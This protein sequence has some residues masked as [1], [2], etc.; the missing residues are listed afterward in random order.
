MTPMPKRIR[1]WR[2]GLSAVLALGLAHE[3]SAAGPPDLD[4][5]VRPSVMS[6]RSATALMTGVARA[7][8]RLVAVGER[9]TILVSDDHGAS[10][11]QRPA[12]VSVMLTNVSFG[13]ARTGWAV[14]HGGVILAT[15]DAG[16]TW[17]LQLDGTRAAALVLQQAQAMKPAD[18]DVAQRAVAEAQRLVADGAD[19]P[20]LDLL[21]QGDRRV[22]AVGAYGLAFLS[23]DGGGTWTPWQ[24]RLPNE[25]GAHLYAIRQAGGAIYVAGEQGS[26]FKSTDQGQ[27]FTALKPPYE[28]SFFGAAVASPDEV[29]VM[30][31]RGNA[32]AS[33]DGGRTWTQSHLG[34]T[35]SL[36]AG[37]VLGD[38]SLVAVSQAGNV[39][40]SRDHGRTFSPVDVKLPVPYVGVVEA[41]DGGLVMAGVR[42]MARTQ[43]SASAKQP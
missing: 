30:G 20:F 16:D 8:T 19:K 24:S 27:T 37:A 41:A 23:E 21:V 11:R 34:T 35:A 17:K 18:G 2:G 12:P 25:K 22:L 4:P 43:F 36:T 13:S 42:G 28:G 6:A 15:S 26:V 10:W 29:V 33:T 39:L 7:G 5:L 3:A 40:R 32:F 1:F 9:G 14:G 31:L 38:G